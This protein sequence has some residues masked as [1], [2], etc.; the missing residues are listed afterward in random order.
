MT[1]AFKQQTYYQSDDV[2][3]HKDERWSLDKYAQTQH[4]NTARTWLCDNV[5]GM[6][7]QLELGMM[8]I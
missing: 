1:L 7:G 2:D 5:I 3:I 6:I 4:S 8:E